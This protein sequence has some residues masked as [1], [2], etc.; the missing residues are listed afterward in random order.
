MALRR[1][2][3]AGDAVAVLLSLIITLAAS[4]KH[5]VGSQFLWGLAAVP[6]MVVMFKLYGLYDRDVKRISYSTVDDLPRLF[7]ATVIGGLILW[8]YAR[9]T[10]M[11]RLDFVEITLFGLNV[12]VLVTCARFILRSLAGRVIGPEKALLVGSGEM[13]RTLLGKLAS[14]PEYRLNVIGSLDTG[15]GEDGAEQLGLPILGDLDDLEHVAERDDVSRVMLAVRD[16]DER[17]LERLLRRC[18]ELS[19][20]V[21][22]I[23][24]LSDVLG[25]AVEV[26]DVE[27]VTVLG[28]NP[29]YLPR[30]SRMLKRTSDIVIATVLLTVLLPILL[31]VALAIKLSSR[32]PVFFVQ[33][34]VGRAGGHFRLFKLRT[35]VIDA[36]AQR[37]ALLDQSADPNWL[38][39]D[40]DPR[41][42]PLGRRLRRW[43]ID[44]LPQ[45]WNVLRG[46]MSMVGPRPLIPAEDAMVAAWA[47]RRLDLTPGITGYWQVLGRT[48]IPFEEMVKLDYLY[49]INWSLWEDVRL[50]FRTLPA[51]IAGRGAN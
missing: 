33:E 35:M 21:S 28:L 12:I 37:A 43:S 29:P 18:R 48:R 14:H 36:E 25:P 20:K 26:D 30:S 31:L 47:R 4:P 17:E 44:E 3:G 7:H 15:W 9:Y 39:L 24:K 22:V 8:L 13:V 27:G 34:R 11:G 1:L 51:V 40:R 19:L 41:I 49:V 5:V 42:T 50:M 38:N 45:L 6:L 46:E 2:L 10:P 32:G 16:I 23:P